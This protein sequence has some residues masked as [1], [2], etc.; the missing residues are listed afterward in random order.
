MRKRWILL[1]GC[2]LLAM[3]S[4]AQI[5]LFTDSADIGE[6]DLEGG[7]IFDDDGY[8]VWGAGLTIGR[9]SLRD[10]FQFV[11]REISGSFIIEGEPYPFGFVGEGGFMIRQD[12]D[13]DSAHASW[14]RVSETIPG[15]NTNA[16]FGTLFPHIRSLKGGPS[17]V[18]GDLENGYDNTD[19]LGPIQLERIGDSINFYSMNHEGEWV[20]IREEV[21]P[22][23]ETVYVGL[24]VTAN[25]ADNYGE[26]DF[27][28]V[29][30]EEYPLWV[31]RSVP[32]DAWNAGEAIQVTLTAKANGSA[33]GVVTEVIPGLCELSDASASSGE[34]VVNAEDGEIVW[35]LS[36]LSD[37]ATLTY[38]LTLGDRK[39]GSWH[40]TFSDG[41]HR[42]GYIAGDS[43][44][45]KNPTWGRITEPVSIDPDGITMI[46]VEDGAP[47]L[48]GDDFIGL[49]LDPKTESG[50][51]AVNIRGGAS[52]YIEI[53][54][55]IQQA[56]RYYF[57]G[58]VRGED[59]NS[60]SVHFEIDS[61]P[62]SDNTTRWDTSGSRVFVRD[63]VTRTEGTEDG[64]TARPFDLD[65]GEHFIA[66]GNRETSAGIDWIAAT[67]DRS[68]AINAFDEITGEIYDP[69][70][71]L[72]GLTELGVFDA[73]QDIFDVENP[74]NLGADGGAAF[75]P[76]A[77]RYVV[78]GSGRDIWDAADNFHFMYK[79]ISG[80]FSIESTLKVDAGTSSS[81]WVKAM[82]MARQE[83]DAESAN[84]GILQ[85]TDGLVNSQ[86]RLAYFDSSYS[87]DTSLR[88]TI[89]NGTSQLK[90]EREGDLFRAY[91][92]AEDD[93][94]FS[95]LQEIEV[96]MDDPILVGL[97]VTAH[98]VN[99]LSIGYFSD[100]KLIVNGVEVSVSDWALY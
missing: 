21:I 65:A 84:A 57:F 36:G 75:D 87:T 13:P 7:V 64:E 33:S 37:E 30:I 62:A 88:P 51:T 38:S 96:I 50:V 61:A 81:E 32:I 89:P 97:A 76:A 99:A 67:M 48:E 78:V 4:Y 68:T 1:V 45:P 60:D 35:T 44:L 91:Y 94:E 19:N 52:H 66:I 80:D 6:P 86:W 15:G 26:Y 98:E 29:K 46:Q 10:Q 83:L 17:I 24:A 69:M 72:E 40:G 11:Y 63:W 90:L 47:P 12:L 27:M 95:L 54:I 41:I 14:L 70:I 100:V 8:E 82:L 34:I 20:W 43:V 5:G 71:E 49:S 2:L 77:G 23:S 28:D 39:S 85:R 18:D 53:P 93:S 3:S 74:G 79:E 55:T 42:D 92:K 9:E 56:G 25:E 59:G 16:V 73:Q 22:M 31:G 58:N